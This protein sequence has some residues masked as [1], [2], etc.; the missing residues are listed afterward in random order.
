MFYYVG[1]R[2]AYPPLSIRLGDPLMLLYQTTTVYTVSLLAM[3][4]AR[5]GLRAQA[6]KFGHA[7]LPNLRMS[8]SVSRRSV[9]AVVEAMVR[10]TFVPSRIAAHTPNLICV[11]VTATRAR[12]CRRD[13]AR[14]HGHVRGARGRVRPP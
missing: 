5:E 11:R 10:T 8:N 2:R 1:S 12:N 3:L 14:Y 7:S 4:N 9:R 6:E 13:P